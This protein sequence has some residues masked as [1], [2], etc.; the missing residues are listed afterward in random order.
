MD[1]NISE[2]SSLDKYVIK[3]SD[4]DFSNH[5]RH[6]MP[7]MPACSMDDLL[8]I[9]KNSDLDMLE[10]ISWRVKHNLERP[11]PLPKLFK[12]QGS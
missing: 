3:L 4:E 8:K 11:I 9:T 6:S 12:E 2:V 5:Q 10:S 7:E 1:G